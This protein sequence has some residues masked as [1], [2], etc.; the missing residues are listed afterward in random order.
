MKRLKINPLF[1]SKNTL[2]YK[3]DCLDFDTTWVE[4]ALGSST[5]GIFMT[6][7]KTVVR[8]LHA[9]IYSNCCDVT[10]SHRL[11]YENNS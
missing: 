5:G 6:I 1:G 10:L 3:K 9:Y 11:Y 8:M 7:P 2:L 4:I